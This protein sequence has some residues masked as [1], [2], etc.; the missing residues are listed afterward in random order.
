MGGTLGVSLA[1]VSFG[2][3]V[4][5]Q[6]NTTGVAQTVSSVSLDAGQ[7]VKA[8]LTGAT[9]TV[10]GQSMTATSL[11]FE[12]ATDANGTTIVKVAVVGLDVLLGPSG[13]PPPAAYLEVSDGG[14]QL[15]ITPHGLAGAATGTL[16]INIPGIS[17]ITGSPTVE[18]N[19]SVSAV[20]ET[21]ALTSGST[22]FDLPAG[23]YVRVAFTNVTANLGGLAITGDF[24]FDQ[25]T[26]TVNS[27]TSTTQRLAIGNASLAYTHSGSSYGISAA[28][29]AFVISPGGVAGMLTGKIAAATGSFSAGGSI[30]LRINTTT[31]AVNQT[32][33]LNGLAIPI[34]FGAAEVKT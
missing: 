32:I 15:L 7:Y 6:I 34:V 30:G 25:T 5:V 17:R 8:V 28:T 27:V 19:T 11:S 31:S 2:G 29:G 20:H 16:T 14:G 9:L 23:P 1:D 33:T 10:A 21:F 4:Q 18:F 12:K 24:S 26:R 3:T 22:A 13:V